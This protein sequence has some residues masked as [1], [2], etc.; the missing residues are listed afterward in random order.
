MEYLPDLM[1]SIFDQT[2]QDFSVRIIDNASVD[3]VGEFMRE[4]Y[5]QVTVIRNTRNLGFGGAHNQGIRYAIDK[6][7]QEDGIRL[8][9]GSARCE[10]Q[11]GSSH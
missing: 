1:R 6:W 9:C 11:V 7:P 10:T 8:L 4:N 2:Y 5:P 3:H